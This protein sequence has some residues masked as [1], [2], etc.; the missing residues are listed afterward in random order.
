[1]SA[2]MGSE[3]G[4]EMGAE[5]SQEPVA[6]VDP[7][8]IVE[9]PAAAHF[10]AQMD[11]SISAEPQVEQPVVLDLT[12]PVIGNAPDGTLAPVDGD[13]EQGEN[14]SGVGAM[15]GRLT[16]SQILKRAT[17]GRADSFT[18]APDED[19]AQQFEIPQAPG[20]DEAVSPDPQD[21]GAPAAEEANADVAVDPGEEPRRTRQGAGL[22]DLAAAAGLGFDTQQPEEQENQ[23]LS[24]ARRAARAA[25]LEAASV[26]PSPDA[27]KAEAKRPRRKMGLFL[28]LVL[29]VVAAIAFA[30]YKYWRGELDL[31]SIKM[32]T[33]SSIGF[34]GN[35]AADNRG[36]QE[37]SAADLGDSVFA[38]AQ[39][40]VYLNNLMTN[41]DLEQISPSAEI[42][43]RPPEILTASPMQLGDRLASVVSAVREKLSVQLPELASDDQ[44]MDHSETI[45]TTASL[46]D[47]ASNNAMMPAQA[48]PTAV[49]PDQVAL[50]DPSS[51]VDVMAEPSGAKA[52]P[53]SLADSLPA[54]IGSVGLRQAALAN[55]PEAQFEIASRFADGSSV[56]RDL[57]AAAH[58][59]EK[60]A[61]GGLAPAQYRLGSLYEK[62][63]GVAVDQAKAYN[64]YLQAAKAGNA[65]AMHNLAALYANGGEVAPDLVKAAEWFQKAADHGV[66]D[67]Q[68]NMGV[69]YSR[70]LGVVQD[71]T[72]A[73]KWFAI[74][75][76]SGDKQAGERRDSIANSLGQDA[77]AEALSAASIFQP[78]PLKPEANLI[79]E[80]KGGWAAS[81][82]GSGVGGQELVRQVQS[83]LSRHGFDPGPADGL[84]GKRTS[85][86]I[87][88]FQFE[89]GLPVTGRA[90]LALLNALQSGVN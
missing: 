30:G 32:P 5:Y 52:S 62:G 13:E 37:M 76:D 38:E 44:A 77:L 59:Y 40:V 8:T 15:L 45:E 35:G 81:A 53:A 36:S 56:N 4:A 20:E 7:A 88:A 66:R 69:L 3:Y 83:L 49:A 82:S 21:T 18:P 41:D 6:E 17:G 58:W 63:R 47:P 55:I 12:E 43:F 27:G 22:G 14:K 19:L 87:E 65:K 61:A 16:S 46:A 80:P 10:E 68:F 86:A 42:A 23:F 89:R 28:V 29:A 50:A 54:S 73:Y 31:N 85:G 9:E 25:V 51:Q 90:D 33:L 60:A 24:A 67:S 70:G 64:L 26:E 57:A 84:M 75:A 78:L 34:F 2:E 48:G 39:R 11:D 71:L 79:I 74:A 1:M 72:E